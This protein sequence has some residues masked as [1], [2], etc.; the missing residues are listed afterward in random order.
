MRLHNLVLSDLRKTDPHAKLKAAHAA[1]RER[2]YAVGAS[3]ADAADAEVVGDTKYHVVPLAE[4]VWRRADG[5]EVACAGHALYV[6]HKPAG[7]LS[8]RHPAERSVY[9]LVPTESGRSDLA[10]FGRLDRDTSG[11]LLFGS[12]G[13]TQKLLTFPTSRVWKVYRATLAAP[14]PDA[15]AAADAFARGLTL[16][17]GTACLP[18]T[19]EPLGGDGGATVRV[20]LHE[21]FFHQVKRMLAHVGGEVMALYRERFGAISDEG[22]SP[23]QMR[24]LSAGEV[25]ALLTMVPEER[26]LSTAATTLPWKRQKSNITR[27]SKTTAHFSACMMAVST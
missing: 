4:R 6:L 9:D 15:P 8:Q 21:G 7:L 12:D 1:I 23:G 26:T 5:E 17:D 2:R 16:T 20:T 25:A 13:G 14:L 10:A 24:P 3:A 11:V 27:R 18:A 22:L 19:L